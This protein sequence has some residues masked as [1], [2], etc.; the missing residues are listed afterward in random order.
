MVHAD[1][2]LIQL[3][4]T[5]RSHRIGIVPGG[6]AQ[7]DRR[8]RTPHL[9]R[10]DA[11]LLLAN[12]LATYRREHKNMPARVVVHKTSYFD[13]DE[14]RGCRE[15]VDA[16]RVELLDLISVRRAAI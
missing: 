3:W 6:N 7:I 5:V 9:S 1:A 4:T 10:D 11:R 12:G 15:A 13:A 8:D 16:E 14:I 2:A